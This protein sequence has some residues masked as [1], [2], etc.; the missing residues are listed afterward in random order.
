MA[1]HANR[2]PY[3]DVSLEDEKFPEKFHALEIDS[4]LEVEDVVVVT[5]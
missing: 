2:K 3:A 1:V 4:S 5:F